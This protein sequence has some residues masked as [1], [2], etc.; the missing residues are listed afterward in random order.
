MADEDILV[1]DEEVRP[2]RVALLKVRSSIPHGSSHA[3]T[4]TTDFQRQLRKLAHKVL[5]STTKLLPRWKELCTALKVAERILPRD[6]R[7]RWNSTYDML[8]FALDYRNVIDAI[9]SERS[10]G[11]HDYE[12][13]TEE[14]S[15]MEQLAKIL[16]D[17]TLFFSRKNT[18][19]LATVIP[20]MDHIERVFADNK[21]SLTFNNAIRAALQLAKRMLN[22]YYSLTDSSDTYRIA[23]GQFF[24]PVTA[25]RPINVHETVLHP[26]HK[27]EYFR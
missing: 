19:S 27:L 16:K 12:L 22:R 25:N 1:H 5:F 6:V 21:S 3:G 10:L 7:T 20:A 15:T 26:R 2:V 13:S 23:M 8:R 18:P 4:I 9:S 14:W 17:P 24:L 11:L